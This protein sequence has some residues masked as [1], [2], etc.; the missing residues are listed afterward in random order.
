MS[1]KNKKY[2]AA[3][4]G[5]G[6][7]AV[8]EG[9]FH[10][11]FQ[12]G[13]H[14]GAYKAH[15][16]I[17]IVGFADIDPK[18]LRAAA[19]N[20]P[21]VPLFNSTEEMLKK[22]SPDIVSIATHSDT[23]AIFVKLAAKYR[24][25]AIVCEKPA[26]KTVQEAKEMVDVCRASGS[27]LFI[28]HTQRFDPLLMKLR[29]NVKNGLIG[30]VMQGSYYYFNGIFNNGSHAVDFLR[31]FLGEIDW[32]IAVENKLAYNFDLPHLKHDL[33]VDAMLHFK[34]GAIVHLHPLSANYHF[35]DIYFFGS[36][37]SLFFKN[38]FYK[39][40]YRKLIKNKYFKGYFGLQEKPVVMGGMRSYMKSMP[41]HVVNCLD[42]KSRP[43]IKAEDG[44]ATLKILFALK[45]SALKG[46][47]KISIK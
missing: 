41:E 16:R 26:A 23:H 14:A 3:I 44:L 19:K 20:F 37:G 4:I 38:S 2:T 8:E 22:T 27:L 13:T 7:I 34:S 30:Q 45:E 12:P 28:N 6:K 15:P 39:I 1:K 42:G 24:I 35:W 46:G 25:K 11:M 43:V 32:V 10:K 29:K 33:N 31:F 21:G 47:K 40:E 17:K 36:K 5:C 18:R 9:I